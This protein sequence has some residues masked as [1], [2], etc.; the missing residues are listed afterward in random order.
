MVTNDPSLSLALSPII[1]SA[2]SGNDLQSIL[3]EISGICVDWG[4]KGRKATWHNLRNIREDIKMA[5][6]FQ[7]EERA[8]FLQSAISS[9]ELVSL[10]ASKK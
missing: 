4:Q 9:M 10:M 3:D 5:I 2:K 7:G 6:S 1:T 8:Y